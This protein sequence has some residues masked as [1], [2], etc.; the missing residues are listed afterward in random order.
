M[1]ERAWLHVVVITP[2]EVNCLRFLNFRFQLMT[3]SIP[4]YTKRLER[5]ESW[6]TD[7]PSFVLI[8]LEVLDKG[9]FRLW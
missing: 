5:F 7:F 6:S 9:N 2:S 8:D 4:F 1:K 3:L